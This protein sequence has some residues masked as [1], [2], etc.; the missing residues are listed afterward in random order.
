[1]TDKL[2]AIKT[3]GD[4]QGLV[5]QIQTANPLVVNSAETAEEA[6]SRRS[7]I[8]A[9][10][11]KIKSV[12]GPIVKAAHK[13]HKEAKTKENYFCDP[14]LA[15]DKDYKEGIEE[16]NLQEKRGADEAMKVAEEERKAMEAFAMEEAA[17][18]GET[19][20]PAPPPAKPVPTAFVP[21]GTTMRDNWVYELED[22]SALVKWV[23]DGL[24]MD[25]KT[26]KQRLA[27]V[28]ANGELL[29]QQAASLQEN[30][31]IPG[32]KVENKPIAVRKSG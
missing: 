8:D 31:N 11:K 9:A 30:L 32:V 3:E 17:L 18:S 28:I 12:F 1:M 4:V 10:I 16:W 25:D 6:S 29:R 19:Q 21:S 14:L 2:A 7:A 23:A 26:K 13:A 20:P 15:L 24:T 5:E 22:F 27:Y